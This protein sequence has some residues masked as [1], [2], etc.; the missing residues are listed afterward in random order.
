[1]EVYVLHPEDL[2]LMKLEAGGPRDLLDIEEMLF[3]APSEVNLRRLKRKA[4]Q[5]RLGTELSKCLRRI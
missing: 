5:L 4:A 3:K 2:I 1:M